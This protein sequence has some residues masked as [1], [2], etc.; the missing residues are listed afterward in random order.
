MKSKG[1]IGSF[2]F[3]AAIV[4]TTFLGYNALNSAKESDWDIFAGEAEDLEDE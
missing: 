4:V 3:L 2:I 1:K